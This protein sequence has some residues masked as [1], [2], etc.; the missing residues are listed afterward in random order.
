MPHIVV[1]PPHGPD[2]DSFRVDTGAIRFRGVEEHP[3][4]DF[5]VYDQ[6]VDLNLIQGVGGIVNHLPLMTL[7]TISIPRASRSGR[8]S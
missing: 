7:R 2:R 1:A 4:C 8:K 5:R 3:R 6:F